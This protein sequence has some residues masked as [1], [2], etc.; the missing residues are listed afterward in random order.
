MT[1]GP[2]DAGSGPLGSVESLLPVWESFRK[3]GVVPCPADGSPMALSV[4]GANAS[5][6]FVCTRC[7][8]AS[9]WFEAKLSHITLRGHTTPELPSDP[10]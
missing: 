2:S 6:R 7:G 10:E 1:D 3:G 4:D 8:V 5:Y 9:T